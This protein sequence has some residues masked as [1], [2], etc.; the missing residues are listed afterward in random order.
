MGAKPKNWN[1]LIDKAETLEIYNSIIERAM[2]LGFL[3]NDVVTGPFVLS[4]NNRAYGM[5]CGERNKDGSHSIFVG[6]NE[7]I[8]K[9][10]EVTRIVCVHEIAHACVPEEDHSPRW[11]EVG[12]KIGAPWGI[13]VTRTN[14]YE[15]YGV[16]SWF[17]QCPAKYVIECPVCKAKWEYR[18][19]TQAVKTPE[20]YECT[21]CHHVGLVRS[22]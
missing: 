2:S 1:V 21:S 5:C 13:V 17:Q 12:D 15:K 20:F 3:R 6:L 9:S 22:L 4:K 16:M 8:L 11:K 10:N 7:R 18:R 14:N 19:M